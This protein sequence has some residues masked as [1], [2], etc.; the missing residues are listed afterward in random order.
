[1]E[2]A[3]AFGKEVKATFPIVHDPKSAVFDKFGVLGYPTNLIIG[4]NGKVSAL[5]EGADAAVLEK[6][7]A[8]ALAAK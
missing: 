4:K 6:A 5:V 2:E 3:A 7:V 1:M 8:S